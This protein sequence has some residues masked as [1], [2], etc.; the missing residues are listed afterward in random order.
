MSHEFNNNRRQR[1]RSPDPGTHL[2]SRSPNR[3]IHIREH[4]FDRSI[5]IREHSFDRGM[6]H[7]NS[8]GHG[9]H[10]RSHSPGPG[11]GMHHHGHSFSSV[12]PLCPTGT[13]MLNLP[14]FQ[15]IHQASESQYWQKVAAQNQ[16]SN[17]R[18][19]RR[20]VSHAYASC[21]VPTLATNPLALMFALGPS[22]PYGCGFGYGP[23]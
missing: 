17:S 9:M 7:G 15:A 16:Q 21:A 6:H 11:H 12:L 4:S 8:F 18:Y 2:R 10:H 3:S 22:R 1:G 19:M 20:E 13:S 23:W 5:H 14:P